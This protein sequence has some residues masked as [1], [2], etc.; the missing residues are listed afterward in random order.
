M[1]TVFDAE[2]ETPGSYLDT[3]V[4]DG[5]KYSDPEALARSRVEADQ[6]IARIEA[7]N[8]E[9]KAKAAEAKTVEELLAKI[10]APRVVEPVANQPAQP[11]ALTPDAVAELIK[12]KFNELK[13]N[14]VTQKN[15]GE[16]S[17]RMLEL[18]GDK[19][20]EVLRQ[21]AA[22]LEVPVEWLQDI[23]A[24]SPKAFYA[25]LGLDNK[26]QAQ[27]GPTHGE[28]NPQAL[29]LRGTGLKNGTYAYYEQMRKDNPKQYS[30][31]AVQNQMHKDA[32]AKGDDFYT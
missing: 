13:T 10:N 2:N 14:D 21:R 11:D 26:Q 5:K 30:S 32:I 17:N 12:D 3:L 22:D 29:A 19:A 28:V 16:V 15:L 9:Y 23:A 18:Y 6:H 4:G 24:R 27:S 20:N 31:A 7:E 25:Q 1:S 8:A